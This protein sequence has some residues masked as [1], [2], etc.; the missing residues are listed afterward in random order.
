MK[1]KIVSLEGLDAAGKSSQ[2]D[3]II[4]F[5][6]D[7]KIQSES[8]HFPAYTD[9]T[10]GSIISMYLK[11]DFGSIDDVDPYFVAS[12]Y[13]LN[14]YLFL[15]KLN[16]LLDRNDV[17]ILDRYVYSNMAFQGAKFADDEIATRKIMDWIYDFEFNALGLPKCNAC[18]F[19]DVP[20]DTIRKRLSETRLGADRE[21]L[22]GKTD[23]H[24]NDMK[25]Q[26][27][28]RYNYLN[29]INSPDYSIVSCYN[30]NP[31]DIFESYVS[32]INSVL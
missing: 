19:L 27:R 6:N 26:E 23:I 17:V 11:G 14:R 2:V 12:I 25:F 24:E 21:Y 4:K 32:V 22:D 30:R 9:N 28:V 15:E 10:Y 1:G 20:I 3:L 29:L 13:A 8:I 7:K 31:T 16:D 18:I 5:L